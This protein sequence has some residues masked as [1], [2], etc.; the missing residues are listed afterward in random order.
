MGGTPHGELDWAQI[1]IEVI[2]FEIE[3]LLIVTEKV[4]YCVP[5]S[6]NCDLS[7][8]VCLWQNRKGR[9]RKEGREG[10]R[11]VLCATRTLWMFSH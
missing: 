4:M 5:T 11:A 10:G 7:R 6:S 3:A 9:G 8:R 1:P 2:W